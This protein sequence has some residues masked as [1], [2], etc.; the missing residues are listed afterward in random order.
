MKRGALAHA[1]IDVAHTTSPSLACLKAISLY[2]VA[3]VLYS[4]ARWTA[5]RAHARTL[6]E[7]A[8]ASC[9]S[10]CARRAQRYVSPSV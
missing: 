2:S 6:S 9:S 5:A 3:M 8:R 1:A 10:A 7:A 4:V